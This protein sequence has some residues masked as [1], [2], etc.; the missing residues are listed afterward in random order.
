M[1][2]LGK[3]H[4]RE[5]R[6]RH[7][8]RR[9]SSADAGDPSADAGD[10]SADAGDLSADAGGGRSGVVRGV[11]RG[12][13]RGVVRGVAVTADVIADVDHSVRLVDGLGLL[14]ARWLP[15]LIQPVSHPVSHSVS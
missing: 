6:R 7:V 2:T 12:A 5:H 8:Q 13:V 1:F 10:L 9:V 4:L 15:H 11:V 3:A 14:P